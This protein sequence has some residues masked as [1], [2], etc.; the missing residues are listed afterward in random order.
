MSKTILAIALCMPLFLASCNPP[1]KV[2]ECEPGNERIC[3]C[4]NKQ[5]GTQK[6]A[7]FPDSWKART[8]KPCS[9]CF[10][11]IYDEHGLTRI[12]KLDGSGCWGETYDP[13]TP[14]YDEGNSNGEDRGLSENSRHPHR[15][16]SQSD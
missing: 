13:S 2:Y 4:D 6:C 1:K 5:L 16:D 9:C 10:N 3:Q 15:N 12:E 11:R 14:T 8:W 7:T